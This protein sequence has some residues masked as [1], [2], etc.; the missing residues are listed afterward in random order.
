MKTIPVFVLT[1]V[2]AGF[3]GG[4]ASRFFFTDD[5]RSLHF[6]PLRASRFDLVDEKGKTIASLTPDGEFA[7]ALVFFDQNR[8]PR[9]KLGILRGSRSSNRI[10]TKM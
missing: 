6:G 1:A 8:Q 5:L 9:A 4:V 10:A 2:L 7:A 3:A